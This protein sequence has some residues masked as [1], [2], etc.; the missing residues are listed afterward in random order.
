VDCCTS[1]S[2][3]PHADRWPLL[4]WRLSFLRLL[5]PPSGV[6]LTTAGS[7]WRS[8]L[9]GR[10]RVEDTG[11]C[12]S[13]CTMCTG[14]DT[15]AFVSEDWV[16]VVELRVLLLRWRQSAYGTPNP[17]LLQK[18]C[19]DPLVR[20]RDSVHCACVGRAWRSLPARSFSAPCLY[21]GEHQL[22][23]RRLRR[24]QVAPCCTRGPARRPL[25][26]EGRPCRFDDPASG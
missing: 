9:E 3:L 11:C 6:Q 8:D 16:G 14:S 22:W 19:L 20:G 26:C 5:G 12:P 1:C 2:L 18:R 17:R 21:P 23:A 25:C 13:T 7:P 10:F 24:P 15:E 4:H